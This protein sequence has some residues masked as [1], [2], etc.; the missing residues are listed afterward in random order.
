MNSQEMF[1]F[2]YFGN[3]FWL[4]SKPMFIHECPNRVQ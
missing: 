3:E 4:N 2:G 1:V